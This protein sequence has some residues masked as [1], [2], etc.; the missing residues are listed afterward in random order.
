MRSMGQV[1][2]PGLLHD[3]LHGATTVNGALT[4][5]YT[6]EASGSLVCNDWHV[7]DSSLKCSER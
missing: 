6:S 1:L 4:R 7:C 3:L 5:N 2:H